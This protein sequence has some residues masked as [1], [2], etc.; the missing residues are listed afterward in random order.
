ML[1][2]TITGKCPACNYLFDACTASPAFAE[3]HRVLLIY[4]LCPICKG[5]HDSCTGEER[6]EL[7][8]ECFRNFK[9]SE[10]NTAYTVTSS[11]AL[12]VNGGKFIQAWINGVDIPKPLFDAIEAGI[13][14]AYA[15][16]PG[17]EVLGASH[18]D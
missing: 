8:K 5:H 15:I 11:L 14:D 6:S 9:L 16:L 2:D 18:A 17:S 3:G 7:A 12:D 13:V 4:A 1:A 10:N